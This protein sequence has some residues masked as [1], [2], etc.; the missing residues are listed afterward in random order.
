MMGDT[1]LAFNL[2]RLWQAV[3]NDRWDEAEHVWELITGEH[4]ANIKSEYSYAFKRIAAGI[5]NENASFVDKG[6]A[7]ILGW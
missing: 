6:L 5:Q 3:S 1:N 7:S 4:G 2:G